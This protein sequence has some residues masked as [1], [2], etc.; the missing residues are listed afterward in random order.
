MK[1]LVVIMPEKPSEMLKKMLKAFIRNTDYL[2]IDN[3]TNLPD[4]TNKNLLFALELNKA[5]YNLGM[6]EIISKLYQ[7]NYSSLANSTGA[8]LIHGKNDLFTKTAAQDLVFH[9]N[10]LGC[11][12]PGRPMVEAIG[13][14]HNFFTLQKNIKK[15]LDEVCLEACRMLGKRFL[16]KPAPNQITAPKLLV[17]HSSNYKTSNTLTL[18]KMI[19]NYLSFNNIKEIHIENGSIRD[20]I[21]CSYKMCKHYGDQIS[22]FY[23]GIMVEEVYPAILDADAVIWICPNYNDGLSA[24]I[25]AVINRLTALFRS[26]K[27]YNKTLFGVIVSGSSGGDALAK[28]LISALNMNKTF[29]LPPYFAIME[30]ANDKNAIKKLSNIEQRAKAFARNIENEIKA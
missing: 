4:L 15:P 2:L 3:T 13:S 18:W 21:G 23:G 29:R 30:T 24:N 28:Q 11:R 20:C 19:K 22:C 12:F 26:N 27:F 17:L 25:S 16:D 14:L 9:A 1:E 6:S 8:V 5:G 7:R 10:M